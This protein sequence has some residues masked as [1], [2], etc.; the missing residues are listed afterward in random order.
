VQKAYNAVEEAIWSHVFADGVPER[1]AVVL[2][3]V[4]ASLGAAKDELARE[5]VKLAAGAHAPVL[6]VAALSRGG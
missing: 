2:P 3:C 1:Y 5:Y 4:S 6:D